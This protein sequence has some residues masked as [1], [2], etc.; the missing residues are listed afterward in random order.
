MTPLV[1][2][3]PKLADPPAG[4]VT[5]IP[6]AFGVIDLIAPVDLRVSLSDPVTVGVGATTI[7]YVPSAD[8]V[9]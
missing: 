3:V 1:T 9:V 6:L 2:I 8:S 5:L 4:T 7:L